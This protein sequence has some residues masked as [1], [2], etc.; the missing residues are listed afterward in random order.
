[1][2]DLDVRP[3]PGGTFLMG[4]TQ[5]ER[6]Q[7]SGKTL[8]YP[9]S[10]NDEGPQHEVEISPF[11]CMAYPV[12][13][14]LYASIMRDD[15]LRR[16]FPHAGAEQWDL[17]EWSKEPDA[18]PVVWVRWLE[19]VL[20]CNFL[21]RREGYAPAY[22]ISGPGKYT[23]VSNQSTFD[24]AQVA[25]VE[26]LRGTNGYRLPTEAEWEYACRAGTTTPWFHG[27]DPAELARYAWYVDTQQTTKEWI[28]ANTR[29]KKVIRPV[30]QKLPNPW[31]LYDMIGNGNEWCNDAP[32]AYGA[33]RVRNPEGGPS[34]HK[35]IRGGGGV[36]AFTRCA[37]RGSFM[38]ARLSPVLGFRCVRS[39]Q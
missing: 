6:D 34:I 19:A 14:R 5:A 18:C 17:E 20:F 12:T 9:N 11:E 7:Q 33:G 24:A 31:G 3:L 29:P 30:G 38:Q 25:R 13:R 27:D 10:L 35:A 28:L 15:P 22:A 39:L 36:V 32:R 2:N 21:S 8:V 26:W 16:F 1:M 23:T 4:S 37:T